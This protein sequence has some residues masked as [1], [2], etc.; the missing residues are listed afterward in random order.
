MNLASALLAP[1]TR[2][3]VY[4]AAGTR[5]EASATDV[6]LPV[7]GA[8][9]RG[10]VVN[11]GRERALVYLGGNAEAIEGRREALAHHLPGHTSYLFGYRGYGAST[12]RPSQRRLTEDAVALFDHVAALHPGAPVDVVGRSLGSG[13]AVQ[14]GVRRPVHRLVLLTPFDSAAGVAADVL[15]WFPASALADR[16]DSAVAAPA[17]RA[18]V[19]VARAGRD[20]LVRQARTEALVAAL[21]PE[22]LVEVFAEADHASIIAEQ[23][24]WASMARFLES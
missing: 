8:T 17:L 5:L 6:E 16:W 7:P 20:V 24:L 11:P 12:G 14:L 9:L 13:V 21:P 3:S 2:R 10:W 19:L 4:P 1:L 23:R 22:S 18:P 15:P